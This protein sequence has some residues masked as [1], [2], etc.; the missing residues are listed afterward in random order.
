MDTPRHTLVKIIQ[1]ISGHCFNNGSICR[2][3]RST[4]AVNGIEVL[5]LIGPNRINSGLAW[6]AREEDFEVVLLP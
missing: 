1:D 5:K 4:T 6:T 2:T 3:L